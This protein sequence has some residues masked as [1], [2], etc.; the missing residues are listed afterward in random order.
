MIR[1]PA[2]VRQDINQ[3]YSKGVPF[4][5]VVDYRGERA[6]AWRLSEVPRERVLYQIGGYTNREKKPFSF[7]WRVKRPVSWE[8]YQK[9][10]QRVQDYQRAGENYL[11][12]LTFPTE[13]EL[14]CDLWTVACVVE[15]PY[16]FALRDECV[17]FSPETFVI[18]EGETI[19]TFPMKGTK[20]AE[21][22]ENLHLLYQDPK[23]QA[24][25]V[26]VVDLLRN[27]LGQVCSSV[28]VKR[29]RYWERV[30]RGQGELFQTSSHI[31]GKLEKGIGIAEVFEALLP[32]GSVTGVPKP[33]ALAIIEEVEGY[34]R[35]WYTG[36]FGLF[37]GKRLTSAVMIRYIEK[38]S[39]GVFYKSG[40]GIM[41]YSDP[42][43]EYQELLE[44][45]YVPVF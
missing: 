5:F 8:R 29:Y 34:E 38:T 3:W 10:F 42:Y 41:I 39:Q 19:S 21:G 2:R 30:N 31:E 35:G 1:L 4:L 13:I 40:G 33:R 18:I 20:R 25:H 11:L 44:K 32:A 17:V 24:E 26:A 15:A 7:S 14:S 27:D 37:D 43:Q 45:V 6:S 28:E 36:V 9:A 12:N 23:E 22:E 16:V